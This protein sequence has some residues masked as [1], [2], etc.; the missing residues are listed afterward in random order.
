[1]LSRGSSEG[2]GNKFSD[3]SEASV[4]DDGI[5]IKKIFFSLSFIW[6]QFISLS[7]NLLLAR[8]ISILAVH[9]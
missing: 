1:M 7:S 6:S 4:V 2:S 5:L 3:P 8:H 9:E